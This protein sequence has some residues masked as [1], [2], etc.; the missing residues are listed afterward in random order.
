MNVT[1]INKNSKYYLVIKNH[2][3]NIHRCVIIPSWS[4][5]IACD[6]ILDYN[7]LENKFDLHNNDLNLLDYS[8]ELDP[9]INQRDYYTVKLYTD[10]GNEYPFYIDINMFYGLKSNE[11]V[12]FYQ[13]GEDEIELISSPQH[14]YE[15]YFLG[16]FN[17][18]YKLKLLQVVNSK[19]ILFTIPSTNDYISEIYYLVVELNKK[20]FTN[21]IFLLT[22]I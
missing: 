20:E 9:I 3:R 7:L 10:D 6:K 1:V 16:N 17:D 19:Y 5:F 14:N 8:I 18:L 13:F 21:I 2:K 12:Y 11:K 22:I 15:F 4:N